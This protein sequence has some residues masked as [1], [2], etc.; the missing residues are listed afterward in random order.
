MEAEALKLPF[1]PCL[2][3][4]A[5]CSGCSFLGSVFPCPAP[6]HS[7]LASFLHSFGHPYGLKAGI[8]AIHSTGFL[9]LP[10]RGEIKSSRI[11]FIPPPPA[12]PFIPASLC[13]FQQWLGQGLEGI[14]RCWRE[15]VLLCIL[16]RVVFPFP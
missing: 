13:F 3:S 12:T 10:P 1:F 11:V 14:A 8:L 5:L 7:F 9:T 16:P 4:S 15:G 6:P 2:M